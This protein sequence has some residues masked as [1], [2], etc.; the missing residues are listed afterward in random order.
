MARYY[1]VLY[2]PELVYQLLCRSWDDVPGGELSYV[3]LLQPHMYSP[4]GAVLLCR[5]LP[6]V[7]PANIKGNNH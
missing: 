3:Y 2:L 6:G 5:V 1:N 4:A 7:L